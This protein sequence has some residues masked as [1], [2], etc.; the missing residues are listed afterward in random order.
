M[1]RFLD[2]EAAESNIEGSTPFEIPETEESGID[3]STSEGELS[4]EIPISSSY[5][6]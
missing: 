2:R 4:D 1:S 6:C 3:N 5:T